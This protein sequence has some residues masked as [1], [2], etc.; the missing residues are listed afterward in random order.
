MMGVS[1]KCRL[2]QTLPKSSIAS[3]SRFAVF[4]SYSVWSYSE[5]AATKMMAVTS[6][7]QWIHLRRSL[8]WPPTS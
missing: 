5:M 2:P 7:K 8:R 6:A 1:S 4:S 3:T